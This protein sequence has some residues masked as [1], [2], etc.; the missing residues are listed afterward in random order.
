MCVYICQDRKADKN[1]GGCSE[2]ETEITIKSSYNVQTTILQINYAE[3]KTSIKANMNKDR[4][5]ENKKYL[6]VYSLDYSN[7]KQ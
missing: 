4:L 2:K 5:S 7:A 3:T 6:L 1:T